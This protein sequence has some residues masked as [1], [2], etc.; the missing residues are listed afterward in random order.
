LN[1]LRFKLA[2][3]AGILCTACAESGPLPPN[4]VLITVDTLR[5]DHLGCYGYERPTSPSIDALCQ[6]SIVFE[7]AITP[8]P[9]T[10]PGHASIHTALHPSR[11]GVLRNGWRL[12]DAHRTLAEI[13]TDAGYFTQGFVSVD[14][15]SADNGFAQGFADFDDAIADHAISPTEVTDKAVDS[16]RRVEEP[17]F[18]WV[19]YWDPHGP[20]DPPD[21]HDLFH[22][23]DSDDGPRSF[24]TGGR[25]PEGDVAHVP[26]E[27]AERIVSLY[28]AE[29]HYT[30]SEIG[31][32]LRTLRDTGHDDNTLVMLTSDHG[33]MHMEIAETHGYAFDHGEYL[34]DPNLLVPLIVRLPDREFAG[35]RVEALASNMDVLPTVSDALGLRIDAPPLDGVSLLPAARGRPLPRTGIVLQR[36]APRGPDLPG[37]HELGLRSV[38]WKYLLDADSGRTWLY[39]LT[40]DPGEQQDRANDAPTTHAR[41]ASHLEAWLAERPPFVEQVISDEQRSALEALGYLQ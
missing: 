16:L 3:T 19:H 20:Y 35:V 23:G 7:T 24:V 11:H 28:D 17:F 15:L 18:L 5:A 39:D 27:G 2:L 9:T 22:E 25:I 32:L 29:I 34:F 13:L 21:A 37:F 6:D 33:E 36:R 12:D 1:T 30:D 41:L 38:T 4:V 10:D 8:T 26:T 40:R 31:R 14:H